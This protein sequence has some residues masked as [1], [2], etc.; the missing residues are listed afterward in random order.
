MAAHCPHNK[1]ESI[2]E[3]GVLKGRDDKMAKMM[4]SRWD[5]QINNGSKPC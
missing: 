4:V 2:S 3:M 5:L 1:H